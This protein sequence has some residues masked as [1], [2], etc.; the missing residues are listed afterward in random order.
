MKLGFCTVITKNYLAHAR[1]VAQGLAKFHPDSPFYVLLV[2]RLD[3]A[4]DPAREPFKLVQLED[5]PD[6][7][8][9]SQMKFYYSLFEFCC[10]MKPRL[11]EYMMERTDLN[12]WIFLDADIRIFSG[13]NSVEPYFE[14]AD[15]L[16]NPH[17][18]T[19]LPEN[20]IS[21]F[22]QEA[23]IAIAGLY[24][25]AFMGFKRGD[26]SKTFISWWKKRLQFHS[27]L[28]NF[29]EQRW[30]NFVPLFFKKTVLVSDAGINVAHWNLHERVLSRDAAG[31]FLVNSQPL[32]FFH[33][34]GWRFENPGQFSKHAPGSKFEHTEEWKALSEIYFEDLK[35]NEYEKVRSLPYAFDFYEDGKKIQYSERDFYYKQMMEGLPTEP[36]PFSRGFEHPAGRHSFIKRRLKWF[37]QYLIKRVEK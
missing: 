27:R 29:Y 10:S 23:C 17:C 13:F 33:Y 21:H 34:S 6:Q 15:L 36:F 24:N 7:T 18:L 26:T 14:N 12:R 35:R 5:L 37:L 8:G 4:F 11:Q 16:L 9:I 30:L 25:A 28:Y 31:N 32:I 20:P 3:G 22:D 19:P 1:T 2:D